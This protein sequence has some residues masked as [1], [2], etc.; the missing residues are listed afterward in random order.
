MVQLMG[1]WGQLAPRLPQQQGSD[2]PQDLI[3]TALKL[4]VASLQ[5]AA[6][7][8]GREARQLV[9]PTLELAGSLA[10]LCGSG[11]PLDPESIA[12]GIMAD[13]CHQELVSM[14][15]V[16][17]RL[18]LQVASLVHDILRARA[19]PERVELYVDSAARWGPGQCAVH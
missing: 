12:A 1:V 11:V 6:A 10:D 19:A 4:A 15:V 5:S 8:S 13:A 17:Q 14:E 3:L 7:A 9:A 18:G 16:Q 2:Q